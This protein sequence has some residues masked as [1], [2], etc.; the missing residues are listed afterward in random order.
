MVYIYIYLPAVYYHLNLD[1]AKRVC[2]QAGYPA[3]PEAF[4]VRTTYCALVQWWVGSGPS[5]KAP[6]RSLLGGPFR[7]ALTGVRIY[8][9]Q[10]VLAPWDCSH[11][12]KNYGLKPNSGDELAKLPALSSKKC[13][14]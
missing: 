14:M 6:P 9:S 12:A 3:F 11:T 7:G 13:A 1:A 5:L 2:W 4:L 10:D 8:R